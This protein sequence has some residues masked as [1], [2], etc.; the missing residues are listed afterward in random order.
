MRRHYVN[1]VRRFGTGFDDPIASR[2]LC[3]RASKRVNDFAGIKRRHQLSAF[4]Y[5]FFDDC[6]V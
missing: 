3:A 1:H 2:R 5:N 6:D 4:R